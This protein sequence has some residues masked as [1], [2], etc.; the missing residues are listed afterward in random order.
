MVHMSF[1]T[2]TG[3]SSPDQVWFFG[4]EGTLRLNVSTMTLFGGQRNDPHL[5]EIEIPKEKEGKWRVEE[6][7][8]GA[9]RG[10]EPIAHTSFEDGVKYMEFSEAVTRSAQSGT[11]ISLPL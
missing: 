9:I 5:S 1:S 6:E 4:T 11:K 2:V 10:I 7:F 8:I 3:L